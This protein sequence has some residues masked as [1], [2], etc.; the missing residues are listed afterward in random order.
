VE[1]ACYGKNKVIAYKNKYGEQI[2]EEF[3]TDS[4]TDFPMVEISENGGSTEPV[5]TL[6]FLKGSMD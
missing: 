3:Y 5:A 2:V 6:Q 4:K 1:F